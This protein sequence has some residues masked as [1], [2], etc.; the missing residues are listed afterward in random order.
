MLTPMKRA[1][2]VV[3]LAGLC[4]A[5]VASPSLTPSIAEPSATT[6][7]QAGAPQGCEPV[8]L[9]GPDGGR[10]DLSGAWAGSGV[11]AIDADEVAVFNQ[12][13]SCVYGSVT[14]LDENGHLALT[15]LSG[16]VNPDFTVA[17]EVV[18]IETA[19]PEA[20]GQIG[21]GL[22]EYRTV[23]MVIEWDAEGRLRLREDREPGE[24][25]DICTRAGASCPDPVIWYAV[26][27]GPGP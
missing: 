19:D 2:L 14:E 25:A 26:E 24:A 5:C 20:V 9:R 21:F 17:L 11:L 23:V 1:W 15:N 12:I 8:E 16:R 4:T 6:T 10:V 13:G 18:A 3:V 22:P 7:V 27:S